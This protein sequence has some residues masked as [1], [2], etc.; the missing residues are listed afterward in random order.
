M[1][2]K[3]N[4]V[5]YQD[6][7]ASSRLNGLMMVCTML[8]GNGELCYVGR[9]VNVE[10]EMAHCWLH[11]DITCMPPDTWDNSEL[12]NVMQVSRLR[13]VVSSLVDRSYFQLLKPLKRIAFLPFIVDLPWRLVSYCAFPRDSPS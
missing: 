7:D 6:E 11:L 3:V 9:E 12:E 4:E 1:T 10:V 8:T 2:V 13:K 5:L